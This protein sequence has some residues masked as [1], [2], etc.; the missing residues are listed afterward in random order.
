MRAQMVFLLLVVAPSVGFFFCSLFLTNHPRAGSMMMTGMAIFA[1]IFLLAFVAWM[2]SLGQFLNSILPPE[3]RLRTAF[4]RF[5]LVYPVF[6]IFVFFKVF[7][8]PGPIPYLGVFISLH[9]LGMICMFYDVLFVSKALVLAEKGRP[10]SFIDY[11]GPF[12]LLWFYPIGIWIIQP[13]VN[14]LNE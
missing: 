3:L 9:L 4:F 14:A 12:F 6:Y 5:A 8:V 7:I 1:M 11:A 13:R 10:V 2:G